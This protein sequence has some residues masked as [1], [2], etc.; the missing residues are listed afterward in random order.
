MGRVVWGVLVGALFAYQGWTLARDDPR[1]PTASAVFR[2]VMRNPVGRW[3]LFGA[4]MWL[5]WHLFV[6]GW[7]F[8]LRR[9]T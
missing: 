6:R 2:S 7:E 4:W 3:A 5:G 8:F 1:W 9:P